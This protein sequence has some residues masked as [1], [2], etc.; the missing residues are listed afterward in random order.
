MKKRQSFNT[1]YV[2]NIRFNS[3]FIVLIISYEIWDMFNLFS[4][5]E[6]AIRML[7][8]NYFQFVLKMSSRDFIEFFFVANNW[9]KRFNQ[10]K[11]F[12]FLFFLIK[13]GVR[14]E[15]TFKEIVCKEIRQLYRIKDIWNFLL[16]SF[17]YLSLKNIFYSVHVL[18]IYIIL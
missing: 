13:K 5:L 7:E 10:Q 18:Q 15:I 2:L 12:S 3:H 11:D 14:K 17:L 9:I 1:I 6:N 16:F 8:S 4:W